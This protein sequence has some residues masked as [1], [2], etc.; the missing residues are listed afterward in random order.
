M[1]NS[2]YNELSN[3]KLV[4]KRSEPCQSLAEKSD[5]TTYD[6]D[7]G[8]DSAVDIADIWL[9]TEGTKQEEPLSSKK[10]PIVEIEKPG[11][12][13]NPK[14]KEAINMMK[15]L[16]QGVT[17][18][19]VEYRGHTWSVVPKDLCKAV[20]RVLQKLCHEPL[21]L[22]DAKYTLHRHT[23]EAIAR[24]QK[25]YIC[26]GSRTTPTCSTHPGKQFQRLNRETN[27]QERH[28][29]C[30]TTVEVVSRKSKRKPGCNPLDKHTFED[31]EGLAANFDFIETPAPITG[32]PKR[33]AVVLDCEMGGSRFGRSELIWVT[34]VDF[35]TGEDLVHDFVKPS[36]VIV[37]WRTQYSGVSEKMANGLEA[38]NHFINGWQQAREL[39]L[40]HIDSD[41]I[42]VG[43]ALN[44]DLDQLRLIHHR[45]I[46]TALTIPRIMGKKHSIQCLSLELLSKAVQNGTNGHDCLEDTLSAREL[47]IWY[48]RHPDEV[49]DRTHQN[50]R[51]Y[52]EANAEAAIRKATLAALKQESQAE[53]ILP[54]KQWTPEQRALL[55]Q[56]LATGLTTRDVVAECARVDQSKSV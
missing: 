32:T 49:L 35:Y 21:D 16:P 27:N 1:T 15:S 31:L 5:V 6:T 7:S 25:C 8:D 43:H 18:D 47:L 11:Q 30:C 39:L 12:T 42:I 34:V 17:W 2:N 55:Q 50:L 38:K 56:L 52:A 51:E 54:S 14:T 48:L 22:Y 41:T 29:T 36:T 20:H 53:S 44:N 33:K 10:G 46:D 19:H 37:D 45:V 23:P 9:P 3:Q 13:I 26:S 40:Q 28:W 4:P 24:M